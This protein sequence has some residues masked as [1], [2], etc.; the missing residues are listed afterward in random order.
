MRSGAISFFRPLLSLWL[1]LALFSCSS[2]PENV[3]AKWIRCLPIY[4]DY[5]KVTIPE[6][7][8]TAEF[9]YARRV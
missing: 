6:G 4:P 2:M 1:A 8:V 3:K 5:I 9:Q 7:I